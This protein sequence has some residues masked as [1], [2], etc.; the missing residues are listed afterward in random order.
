[1]TPEVAELCRAFERRLEQLV[2]QVAAAVF[3]QTPARPR[4]R[5]PAK[6]PPE[7][8][9]RR[10]V[11]RVVM[12]KERAR[13]TETKDDAFVQMARAIVALPD[14]ARAV[15]IAIGVDELLASRADPR[16][17]LEEELERVRSVPEAELLEEGRIVVIAPNDKEESLAVLLENKPNGLRRVRRCSTKGKTIGKRDWIVVAGEIV[18][19]ATE[20]EIAAGYVLPDEP[21]SAVG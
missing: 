19:Y 21:A 7:R 4:R 3:G 14:R 13:Q 16:E 6:E 1:M 9:K 10:S 18:R 15:Q 5:P 2:D 20:P 17:Q 11:F 8:A 12:A